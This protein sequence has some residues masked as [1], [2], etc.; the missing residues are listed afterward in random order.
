MKASGE[1]PGPLACT[2]WS[3]KERSNDSVGAARR[4]NVSTTGAQRGG[5]KTRAG[6][7]APS[8]HPCATQPSRE[9]ARLPGRRTRRLGG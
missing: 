2:T 9:A 5:R 4:P 3:A 8:Q 1:R 7:P 6:R